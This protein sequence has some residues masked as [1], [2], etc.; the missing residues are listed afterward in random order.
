[1][2]KWNLWNGSVLAILGLLV[3]IF[4]AFWVKVVV[5]LLGIGA[6]VYGIYNLKITKSLYD[7]DYYGKTIMIRGIVSILIGVV[8]ILF[9]LAF[10][11]TMWAVMIWVLI[12]YL[13]ISAGLGFYAAALLKHTGI[14]RKKYV[15]ENIALLAIAIVL[16]LISPTGLGTAI[17]R[18][19]GIVAMVIGIVLI[20][21]GIAFKKKDTVVVEAE[22]VN[23]VSDENLKT[24]EK[25]DPAEVKEEK[26][27]DKADS[28]GGSEEETDK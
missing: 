14:N 22:V 23:D 7:G 21:Y 28:D 1:M 25:V 12:V 5:I 17:I 15:L 16:I 11:K 26:Q 13:V 3:I 10:G 27:E 18:I 9:P 6:I 2:K 20:V 19:V 4:P 24:A 8:A